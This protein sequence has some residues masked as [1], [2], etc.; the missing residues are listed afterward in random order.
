M[1]SEQHLGWVYILSNS[2]YKDL[3]KI[4]YTCSCS[5]EERAAQLTG[6]GNPYPFKVEYAV[7]T[8]NAKSVE[9]A[10]HTS[11]G[12]SRV[13]KNREFFRVSL[14]EAKEAIEKFL[15]SDSRPWSSTGNSRPWPNTSS[16]KKGQFHHVECH[17]C[18]FEYKFDKDVNHAQIFCPRCKSQ[19]S[20]RAKENSNNIRKTTTKCTTCGN[21]IR[22]DQSIRADTIRCSKCGDFAT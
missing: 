6:T 17:C 9:Q 5:P 2:G 14:S 11:L 1:E 15:S 3:L 13:S 18:S 4:G 7:Q 10:T 19:Y 16:N 21:S 22:H 8:E 20:Q 12:Y